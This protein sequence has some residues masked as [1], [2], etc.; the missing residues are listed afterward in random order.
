LHDL[1]RC[2]SAVSFS[3]DHARNRQTTAVADDQIGITVSVKIGNRDR[4]MWLFGRL[5]LKAC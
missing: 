2:K 4:S 1:L 5:C 3:Q